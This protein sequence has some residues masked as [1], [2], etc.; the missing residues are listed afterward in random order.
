MTLNNTYMDYLQISLKME[1]KEREYI[2]ELYSYYKNL[3]TEKQK[4][5][6]EE[7]Y[8]YDC[9]LAEIASNYGVSRNACFDAIKKCEN[10]LL[11]YESKLKLNEKYTELNKALNI[12]NI[13]EIKK[14]IIKIVEE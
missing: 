11:D 10:I 1:I 6:F 12:N 3:L 2:I 9:S 5:Y 14:I 8:L 13:D 7:Y 4:S